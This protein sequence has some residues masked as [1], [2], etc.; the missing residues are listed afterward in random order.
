MGK[1]EVLAFPAVRGG[2][3]EGVPGPYANGYV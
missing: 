3:G 2:G 1:T